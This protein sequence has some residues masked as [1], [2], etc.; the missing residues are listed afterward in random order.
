MTFEFVVEAEQFYT[1]TLPAI[2]IA[3]MVL[4]FIVLFVFIYNSPKSKLFRYTMLFYLLCIVGSAIYGMW[5]HRQYSSWH[6]QSQY[7]H[8]G[9]RSFD[10]TLKMRSIEDPSLVQTLRKSTSLRHN[11]SHL[12]IYEDEIVTQPFD[13]DYLGQQ[14]DRHYFAI[15]EYNVFYVRIDVDTSPDPTYIEARRYRLT[16][17]RFEELGFYNEHELIVDRIVVNEEEYQNAAN[18]WPLQA[19]SI[20]EFDIGLNFGQQY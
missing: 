10:F 18:E 16:D 17:E 1:T 13:Y 3:L 9:I 11:L 15:S 14:G 4:L 8:P 6:D 20:G 7:I 2:F 19:R 5:G 12:E